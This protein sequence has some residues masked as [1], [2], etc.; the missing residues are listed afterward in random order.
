[1]AG[2]IAGAAPQITQAADPGAV[3]AAAG[4]GGTSAGFDAAMGQYNASS[5]EAAMRNIEMMIA[6]VENG[7]L[8]GASKQRATPL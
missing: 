1:M 5:E 6:G 4:D 7:T 8:I 3:D 2:E